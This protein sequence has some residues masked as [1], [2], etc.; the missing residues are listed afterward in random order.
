M[1]IK[2]FR[3]SQGGGLAPTRYL[4][5][6]QV[7]A[8]DENRNAVLDPDGRPLMKT[9]DPAP[10]I[11]SGN[12]EQTRLLIDSSLNKHTYTA[13]VLSFATED[14]PTERQQ[15]FV[16]EEFEKVAFADLAPDQYNI[17]WVRHT[18]EGRVELHFCTPRLELRSGKSLNIAPPR[19]ESAF[20]AVCDYVNKLHG[21]AD[22]PRSIAQAGKK[23]RQG[24]H[25]TGS[26]PGG[27]TRLD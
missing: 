26:D 22:P 7:R 27:A 1:L 2:F 20:N 10:E 17:L 25:G 5:D 12:P 9:R 24:K 14:A 3:N 11:I 21:W 19:H 13:G 18:H 15:Q 6:L 23:G 4:T 16:I 8:Y